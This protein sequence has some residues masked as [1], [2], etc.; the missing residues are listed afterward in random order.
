MDSDQELH[1]TRRARLGVGDLN[2]DGHSDA[3]VS[4]LGL[5]NQA[6]INDGSGELIDIG[7]RLGGG[8]TNAGVSLGDLDGDGDLDL[9]ISNFGGGA[10]EVWFN[11]SR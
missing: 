1:G 10:N 9:F 3:V 6:W 2:G 11:L 8:A 5:P 4:N 7:M